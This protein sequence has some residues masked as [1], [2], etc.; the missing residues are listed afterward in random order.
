MDEQRIQMIIDNSFKNFHAKGLDYICL[1]RTPEHTR[2]AYFLNGDVTKLPDVV[3]PHDHRYHFDTT[4]ICGTMSNSEYIESSYGSVYQQ[5]EWRTPLNGGDGFTW[6]RETKLF[7]I[8]R[9]GYRPGEQYRMKADEFHTIRMHSDQVIIILDQYEDVVP[10]DQPT[11]TF[12]QSD[13]APDLNGL[14]ERFTADDVLDRLTVLR[15]FD[16]E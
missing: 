11:L 3:N 2:K 13:K 14:Y 6:K 15:N 9:T 12:M 1:K 7:E 16:V 8:Q 10:V 4:V 5:F